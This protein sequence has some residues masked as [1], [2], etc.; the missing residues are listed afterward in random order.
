MLLQY[1]KLLK[2]TAENCIVY[3]YDVRT[4]E[5]YNYVNYII[6]FIKFQVNAS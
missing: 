6:Q 1:Q 4:F 3:L 2:L 5:V